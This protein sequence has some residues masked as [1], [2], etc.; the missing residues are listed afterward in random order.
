MLWYPIITYKLYKM[1]QSIL[2]NNRHFDC[3]SQ[4]KKWLVHY[5]TVPGQTSLLV[6]FIV[7]YNSPYFRYLCYRYLFIFVAPFWVTILA[8]K[9]LVEIIIFQRKNWTHKKFVQHCR[10][11]TKNKALSPEINGKKKLHFGTK[12]SDFLR[13]KYIPPQRNKKTDVFV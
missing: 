6:T 11:T 12:T 13:E 9:D 10:S 4:S 2:I 3:S 5:T 8:T 1:D 7:E